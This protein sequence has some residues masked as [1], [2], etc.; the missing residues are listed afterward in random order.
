MQDGTCTTWSDVSSH[1]EAD[2]GPGKLL[3]ENCVIPSRRRSS[4]EGMK[5]GTHWG[6]MLFNAWLLPPPPFTLGGQDADFVLP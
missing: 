2:W 4:L 3:V 5:G 1:P 6:F